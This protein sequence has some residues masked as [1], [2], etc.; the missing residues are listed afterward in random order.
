MT[1]YLTPHAQERMRQ[2][3]IRTPRTPGD[4]LCLWSKIQGVMILEDGYLILK[5]TG[6]DTV[7][8]VTAIRNFSPTQGAKLTGGWEKLQRTVF[9]SKQ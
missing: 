7:K 2:R 1:L 6:E 4:F 5:R 9:W 3:R 8:A